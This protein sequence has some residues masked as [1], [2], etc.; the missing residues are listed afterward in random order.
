MAEIE[1]PEKKAR[2]GARPG[3]GMKPGQK[4]KKTIEKE[5][6]RKAYQQMVLENLRPLFQKQMWLAMGQT[7]VYRVVHHGKGANLRIEHELLEEPHE[8]ADALDVIA[9]HD[10]NGDDDGNGFVYVTTKAPD[11]R[12]IDSMLDRTLDKAAQ[13]LKG[14]KEHPLELVTVVK[15]AKGTK[16]TA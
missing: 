1:K 11:N 4:T 3:S 2:G 12:A 7:Y 16:P 13:P 6:A 5:A 9:N 8:I 15:Y 14:D 10:P